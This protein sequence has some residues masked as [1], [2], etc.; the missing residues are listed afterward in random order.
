MGGA[1]GGFFMVDVHGDDVDFGVRRE[2]S[3]SGTGERRRASRRRQFP[4]RRT[5]ASVY[6]YDYDY[7]YDYSFFSFFLLPSFSFFVRVGCA[8]VT[9]FYWVLPGF[10]GFQL[11]GPSI[12]GV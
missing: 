5:T 10:K 2:S 1:S 7:D 4:R 12:H 6:Y 11:V 9:G 3:R 8:G